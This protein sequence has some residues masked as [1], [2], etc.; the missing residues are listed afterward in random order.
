MINV[1]VYV[2]YLLSVLFPYN[3]DNADGHIIDSDMEI[4]T[5]KDVVVLFAEYLQ[6][7]NVDCFSR[8]FADKL[9]LQI[10]D[11]NLNCS[12]VQAYQVL[13]KFFNNYTP[14]NFKIVYRSKSSP[15]EYFVGNLSCGGHNFQISLA[16]VDVMGH[17]KIQQIIIS[18]K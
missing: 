18:G 8:Y 6:D 15:M 5:E 1:K 17:S 3:I 12:K 9:E 11:A 13:K 10:L 2:M 14:T 7:A 16:I 4:K